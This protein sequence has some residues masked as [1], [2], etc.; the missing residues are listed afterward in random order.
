MDTSCSSPIFID[1]CHCPLEQNLKTLKLPD[2]LIRLAHYF[3]GPILGAFIIWTFLSALALALAETA[4]A[5][6]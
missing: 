1:Y 4:S 2:L 5:K 6:C 3:D